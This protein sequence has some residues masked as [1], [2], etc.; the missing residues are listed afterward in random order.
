MKR[1]YIL[2]V[3]ENW[4]HPKM[5]YHMLEMYSDWVVGAAV[6][7]AAARDSFT[8]TLRRCILMDGWSALARGAKL[9]L[10]RRKKLQSSP[11]HF[12]SVE[13][14]FRYFNVPLEY[15][16]DP[17]DDEFVS[18]IGSLD[19]DIILNNQPGILKKEILDV[20]RIG[21]LNR[22]ASKLPDYRGVEPIFH[23]LLDGEKT[24]GVSIHSM[25][26]EID[27]GRVYAQA[28]IPVRGS[29]L[30]CYEKVFDLAPLLFDEAIK[31]LMNDRPLYTVDT[32]SSPCCKRP[33]DKEMRRFREM[34]LR[35]L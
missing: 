2:A 16:G 33:T 14:V 5:L 17:N 34:E 9:W 4:F 6:F 20:P 24:L 27:G 7:P 21:C 23:A 12:P 11:P 15:A 25:T 19:L 3:R 29:V 35:Y 13:S 1:I 26:E 28:E 22:H 31:N 32:A 30:E 10:A 8:S 18:R